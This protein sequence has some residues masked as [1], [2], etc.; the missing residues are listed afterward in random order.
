[1]IGTNAKLAGGLAL[2]LLSSVAL[3]AGGD[4]GQAEKQATNWTAI[5]MFA[6]FVARHPVH[7]QVGGGQDQVGGRLLHRRWRH[8]R[9]PERPRDRR[10]LHVGG[11]LP[12]DLR[13]GDGERL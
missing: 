4:L 7:H 1:M 12:R 10:R 8:H 3:A 9:L 13:G 5:L 2:A 11:V 6:A